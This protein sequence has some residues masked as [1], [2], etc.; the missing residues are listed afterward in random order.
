MSHQF[1]LGSD[2]RYAGRVLVRERDF[3]LVAILTM[4]LAIGVT[5]TLFSVFDAVLLR[6]LPWPRADRLVRFT[7]THAGATRETPLF[8]SSVAWHAMAS[9]TTV[10]GLNAWSRSTVTIATGGVVE[11]RAAASVT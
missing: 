7:E 3:A 1:H 6:P 11:R 10:E 9:L 4:A 5:A 8:V 2:V